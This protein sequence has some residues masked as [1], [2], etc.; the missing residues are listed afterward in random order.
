MKAVTRRNER[1]NFKRLLTS[2][3]YTQVYDMTREENAANPAFL[4]GTGSLV[5]DRVNRIAYV[6][7][8]ARSDMRL[9][10]TWGRVMGYSV[11]PFTAVD[12]ASRPIYHTN[13]MMAI[14]TRVAVV[15]SESIIDPH[16]RAVVLDS[17]RSTGHHVVEITQDQVNNFCGNVLELESFHGDQVMVMST[18]AYNAFTQE[19][20]EA[21]EHYTSKLVHSDISTIERIGGG[22]VR[23]T[24]AEL[25]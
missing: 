22:G 11:I 10:R 8:S 21:I 20:R 24:I 3:R 23:C 25:F 19:Q 13:V 12:D 4:E 9:T 6:A 15:C 7:L 16:E 18:G 1:A 17:L 14:G 5:L 2:G